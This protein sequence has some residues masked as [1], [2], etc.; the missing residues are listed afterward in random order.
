MR[1]FVMHAFIIGI[2]YK[3]KYVS[4]DKKRIKLQLWDTAG[5]ERFHSLVQGFYRGAKVSF[6]IIIVDLYTTL[7]VSYCIV[8]KLIMQTTIGLIFDLL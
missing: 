6:I 4:V 5:Q 2:D 7:R 8:Y 1:T 3:V